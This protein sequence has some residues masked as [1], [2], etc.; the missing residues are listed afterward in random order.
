MASDQD[1]AREVLCPYCGVNAELVDS[2][3]VY[4]R[5]YGKLWLCQPCQAWVGVHKDSRSNRPKGSLAKESLRKLRIEAHAV[6]DPTW[7]ELL[8][9][10]VSRRKARKLLYTRLAD[11]LGIDFD[12]CHIGM[13]DEDRCK[14][15]IKIC[16]GWQ[17]AATEAAASSEL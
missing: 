11:S 4:R 10:G 13:F 7:G 5:S 15:A 17:K 8:E 3:R 16:L 1:E 12:E 14:R 2:T 9:Q 6:F